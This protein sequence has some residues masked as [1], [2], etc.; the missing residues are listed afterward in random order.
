[1]K[2]FKCLVLVALII[3]TSFMSIGC[4]KKSGDVC[5]LTILVAGDG[6]V[7]GPGGYCA[8]ACDYYVDKGSVV[9]LSAIGY[10]GWRFSQWQGSISGSSPN[11]FFT[12][13]SNYLIRAVFVRGASEGEEEENINAPCPEGAIKTADACI[14][15]VDNTLSSHD[16][17]SGVVLWDFTA[18]SPVVYGPVLAED[19]ILYLGTESDLLH[20]IDAQTGKEVYSETISDIDRQ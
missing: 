16:L 11:V 6:R 1:M 18:E 17:L 2:N 10:N 8:A 20:G 7:N 15:I 3:A 12:I 9:Y 4:G 13:N 19:G 5:L 14:S